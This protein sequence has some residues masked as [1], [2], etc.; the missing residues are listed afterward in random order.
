MENRTSF[1]SYWI[2]FVACLGGFLQSYVT[3]VIAGALLF[4]STEFHLSPLNQGHIA[5]IILIGAIVGALSA[6]Y[7]ADRI[8]RRS[9]L[10]LSALIYLFTALGTFLVSSFFSLFILRLITGT[11]V[12]IT[13]ML[14]PIYLAEVAPP[15]KRGAFVTGFQFFVT[16]G[17]LVAYF[18]NLLGASH[19]DW[20]MMLWVA[21]IPAAF[22]LISLFFFPESPKWLLAQGRTEEAKKILRRT[23]NEMPERSEKIQPKGK[24]FSSP[25]LFLILV[26]FVLSAF[27]QLSGINAVVYFAPKI[28]AEAGFS[29]AQDAL[30]ATLLVG[31]VNVIATFLTLFL[32]DRYG[33]RP[34]LLISQVGVIST[35]LILIISFATESPFIDRIAVLAVVGYVFLYSL[36]LG[37]I[38][39]VLISEI[40]PLAIRAKAL[41]FCTF[42]SWVSNYLVVLTFPNFVSF[43]GSAGTFAIYGGLSFLALLFY[44]RYI[45]ET[46]GKSLEEVEKLMNS[47]QKY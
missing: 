8:G 40:Y 31:V 17:T 18:V 37:P 36:G 16:I 4:I 30:F 7:L 19:Q 45:P 5:S 33:R 21:A 24:L 22:Q 38:V 35:L 32:I 42:V 28:F 10:I 47:D 25:Y 15:S 34:L 46:K 1:Y 2:A 13:S 44:L 29:N 3:C 39:W 20:R 23:N 27:Q 12:G 14:V 26:G 9:T 43:L 6:G 41:A 11:A